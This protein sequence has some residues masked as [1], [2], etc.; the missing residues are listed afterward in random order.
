MADVLIPR[1]QDARP[2]APAPI[3]PLEPEFVK[4]ARQVEK[5]L[6]AAANAPPDEA[7]LAKLAGGEVATVL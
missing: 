1:L 7:L 6:V 2:D 4:Y 5:D 3:V